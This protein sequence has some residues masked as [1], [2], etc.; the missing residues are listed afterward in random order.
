MQ[1]GV[2]G[3]RLAAGARDENAVVSRGAAKGARA[4]PAPKARRGLKER[5]VNEAAPPPNE[6]GGGGPQKRERRPGVKRTATPPV[7][8][9]F[10][11]G[12]AGA[13]QQR[14]DVGIDVSLL[15]DLLAG[16]TDKPATP[17][18]LDEWA[19]ECGLGAEFEL[20]MGDLDGIDLSMLEDDKLDE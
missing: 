10:A 17:P 16:G 1:R 7:E 13:S 14:P 5:S 6:A 4:T 8:R 9:R 20:D 15:P 3:Q 19:A 12:A 11:G 18:P 2:G